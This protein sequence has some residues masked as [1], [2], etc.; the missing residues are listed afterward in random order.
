MAKNK[1]AEETTPVAEEV[2]PYP[3]TEVTPEMVEGGD[4]S[5]YRPSLQFRAKTMSE[6]FSVEAKQGLVTG[7]AGDVL[8]VIDD[9]LHVF[10][11][12]VFAADYEP[13]AHGT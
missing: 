13:V 1:E 5:T 9:D 12:S 6:P 7:E 11:S 10:S 2:E 3:L 4:W 8:A